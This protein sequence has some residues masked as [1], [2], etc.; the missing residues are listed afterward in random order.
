MD[1]AVIPVSSARV[2]DKPG[3][4]LS[5]VPLPVRNMFGLQ[6]SSMHPVDRIQACDAWPSFS[7]ASLVPSNEFVD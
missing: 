7:D 5:T 6:M 2:E 3:K 1:I 4:K